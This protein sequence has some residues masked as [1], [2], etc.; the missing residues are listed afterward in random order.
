M[1]TRSHL[2][3][4]GGDPMNMLARLEPR[5]SHGCICHAMFDQSAMKGTGISRGMAEARPMVTPPGGLWLSYDQATRLACAG[6]WAQNPKS[7]VVM[8]AFRTT[9]KRYSSGWGP[10]IDAAT[11]TGLRGTLIA[12]RSG[13]PERAYRALE[14]RW[15]R[16][17]DVAAEVA[18]RE[19]GGDLGKRPPDV[20]GLGSSGRGGHA[21]HTVGTI[22][23]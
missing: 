5:G 16:S 21:G 17:L 15:V 14:S 18:W 9:V 12:G 3:V 11:E 10:D 20:H 13:D 1:D 4:N 7:G 2:S 22:P 19:Q 8:C 23:F 6:H